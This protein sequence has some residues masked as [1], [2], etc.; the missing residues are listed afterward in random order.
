MPNQK[1]L[2]LKSQFSNFQMNL[3]LAQVLRAKKPH[4]MMEYHPERLFQIIAF[5]LLLKI[6]THELLDCP[7]H[8]VK[9]FSKVSLES[10]FV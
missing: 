4:Q 10:I 9:S 2:I 8:T 7:Q 3:D 6:S 1:V 5:H